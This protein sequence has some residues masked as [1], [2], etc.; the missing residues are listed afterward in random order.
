MSATPWE[1]ASIPGKS[2]EPVLITPMK[3][4]EPRSVFSR[5]LRILRKF[6]FSPEVR[7]RGT[8]THVFT[9][10]KVSYDTI[11]VDDEKPPLKT[12][13]QE[14]DDPDSQLPV[15]DL[16][17]GISKNDGEA[18]DHMCVTPVINVEDSQLINETEVIA[19][20]DSLVVNDSL[21]QV[22]P[23]WLRCWTLFEQVELEQSQL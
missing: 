15:L 8:K 19:V 12:I 6:A 5:P 3:A 9:R 20:E 18:D 13:R 4:S 1:D 14:F 2:K 22:W 10:L 7:P 16:L 17:D 23:P 11:D 21:S